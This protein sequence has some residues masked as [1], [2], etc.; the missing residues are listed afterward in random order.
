MLAYLVVG[1]IHGRWKKRWCLASDMKRVLAIAGSDS[2]GGAGIQADIRTISSL[3]A[4]ALTAVTALTAQNSRNVAA[5]QK[6]PARFVSRQIE[7]ILVDTYPDAVKIGMLYTASCV[8]EV[9]RILRKHPLPRTVLDPVLKASTGRALLEPEALAPLQRLLLPRV[10]VVTPNLGEASVLSGRRVGTV[11]EMQEAAR[12]IHDMGPHVVVTGGHLRGACVDVLY[13]GKQMHRFEGGRIA[14]RH[15]HGGGCV[16]STAL[17]V[18]LASGDDLGTAVE[19]AHGFAR[20]AIRGGYA[21]GKGAGA[22]CP[23]GASQDPG[24]KLLRRLRRRTP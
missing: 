8:R 3:G 22:V 5:I 2:G 4:H 18:F 16:F 1:E 23:G 10:L 15:T 24:G 9:A 12:V 17:A 13:D 6:V 19:H 11:R 21:I 7:T 20:N 14:T